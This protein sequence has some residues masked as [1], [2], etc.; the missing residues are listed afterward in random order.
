VVSVSIPGHEVW[1]GASGIAD[2]KTGRPIEASTRMRI[3]SISKMFTAVVV[4]QLAQEG[5][6]DLD[7]PLST[8][9]PNLVP[10]SDT[11]T[12]RELLQHT[13]G[14]YDY[15]EDRNF[16]NRAYREASHDWAPSELVEY[17]VQFPPSFRPG[18]PGA[19]DYSSTNYVLLG[20]IVEKQ[21]G[22]SLAS[23]MRRRIFEPL[24]LNHTFSAPDEPIQGEQSRG[25]SNS[26]DQTNASM[27]FVF[28]TANLVSTPENVQRF[29]RALLDGE[30]LEPE[31]LAA[32]QQ[33][34][35]GKGQYKMPALEY[36]LGI[37]RNRLPV[38][39][40]PDGQP[41][42]AALTT[43]MGHIG[44]YGGFRSAVWSAPGSGITFA[45]G[46]NQAATDPNILATK[47]FDALLK[48][49]G[50]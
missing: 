33:F 28:A 4:L 48:A 10:N 1:S 46:V 29:I 36:G 42:P 24:E 3:A 35:G 50:L 17:A 7:A 18:T 8:W 13:S 20:M 25:Y 22:N 32:M 14:L 39:P 15:L 31:M 44:G 45:L 47:V 23:E 19:W 49:Q 40:G 6:I 38:G 34:V 30:L 43:V 5:Q 12:V 37:M 21:T 41:R 9:L 11:I 2:R 27:S 16:V 26:I